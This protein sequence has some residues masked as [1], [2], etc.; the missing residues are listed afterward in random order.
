MVT[1]ELKS[2]LDDL[3]LEIL[4]MI[5]ADLD[6]ESVKNLRLTTRT[7]AERCAGPRFQLIQPVLDFSRPNLRALHALACDPAISPKVHSLTFLAT[8]PDTRE[9]ENNVEDGCYEVVEWRGPMFQ[10]FNRR[11]KPEELEQAKSDLLWLRQQ[12][13]ARTQE[14]PSEM[15]ELL[16]LALK[17][18]SALESIRFDGGV[19]R[20]RAKRESPG[21]KEWQPVWA[22]ASHVLSSVLTA[23]VQSGVSV[24][25]LDVYR[26]TSRCCIQVDELAALAAGFS[27]SQ[28]EVLGKGLESLQLSMSG[29]LKDAHVKEMENEED[30]DEEE[31]EEE[32]EEGEN[33]DKSNDEEKTPPVIK[34]EVL[35]I[36]ALFLRSA[37]ALRELDL[38]FRR[39]G[40]KEKDYYCYDWVIDRIAH[41]TQFL[42]LEKCSCSGLAAK[43]GSLLL[44]LQK[45]PTLRSLTLRECFLTSGSWT[46]ILTHLQSLPRLETLSLSNLF[47]KHMQ[48]RKYEQRRR[49]PSSP[50]LSSMSKTKNEPDD[51]LEEGD[52]MVVL[53]PVWN[54]PS[55]DRW[56]GW[57]TEYP[58]S[59]GRAVHTR[60]FTREE[61]AK[62]LV[63][64]P[65]AK[66][67]GCAIGS[68]QAM[69]WRN[70]RRE[71]YAPLV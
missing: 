63:F 41:E 44:F 11:Y 14:P 56:A 59:N 28:L 15:I 65:L 61:L 13:E 24:K 20:G 21:Y 58:H 19:I 35:D 8:S 70:S 55:K 12:Q 66:G 10:K 38:T 64:Q 62:G 57:F 68:A 25:R 48:N 47:G 22:R 39:S 5:L 51:E 17:G 3:P 43:G 53:L 52:G 7:L 1:P 31:E 50:S 67:P 2:R 40:S 30:D 29:M 37:P 6:L 4:Q 46:P 71:L 42:M 36:T 45:H 26:N 27:P 69:N 34:D 49:R 33:N 54:V 16:Q 23:M 60:D 18:F 9:L 32:E